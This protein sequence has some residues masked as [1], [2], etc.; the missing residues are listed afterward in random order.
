MSGRGTVLTGKEALA[1]D[2]QISFIVPLPYSSNI[3]KY[4]DRLVPVLSML[5]QM[6]IDAAIKAWEANPDSRIVI[7]GETDYEGLP[8]TTD[9]MAERARTTS[10]IPEDSMIQLHTLPNGRPLNNTN[11][12]IEAVA[13]YLSSANVD[14][15]GG[16]V[17]IPLGFH[18][19]RVARAARAY[20][21]STM[22]FVTA[23]DVL[24]EGGVTEYDD[25]LSYLANLERSERIARFISRIDER[26]K[27]FDLIMRVKGPKIVD[28]VPTETEDV[29]RLEQGFARAKQKRLLKPGAAKTRMA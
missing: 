8:N 2:R 22:D 7:T 23:E 14:D 24:H 21:L 29:Y 3:E 11:R 16:V 28:V 10:D 6:A 9:L 27:L 19:I 18:A 15:S 13:H 5:S 20:G 26:G 1:P 17:G 12:Q 25:R 4:P